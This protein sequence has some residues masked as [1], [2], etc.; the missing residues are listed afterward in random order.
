MGAPFYTGE[1][2][3][4]ARGTVTLYNYTDSINQ[5]WWVYGKYKV[6]DKDKALNGGSTGENLEGYTRVDT[7]D[8]LRLPTDA[9]NNFVPS[10]KLTTLNIREIGQFGSSAIQTDTFRPNRATNYYGSDFISVVDD[11]GAIKV[12]GVGTYIATQDSIP[13]SLLEYKLPNP[14]GFS[15]GLTSSGTYKD[16]NNIT[17][18]VRM[19]GD[20]YSSLVTGNMYWYEPVGKRFLL[21]PK[22]TFSNSVQFAENGWTDGGHSRLNSIIDPTKW[23][24]REGQILYLIAQGKTRKEATAVIDSSKSFKVITQTSGSDTQLGNKAPGTDP[25]LPSGKNAAANN[26]SGT[27]NSNNKSSSNI[28]TTV[29]VRGNF[30]YAGIAAALGS[31]MQMVQMYTLPNESKPASARYYFNPK[32]NQINYQNLGSD[33]T[34]IE[35]VGQVPLV[36]WKNY[37]LMK[38]SFQFIVTPSNAYRP[39]AFG[40]TADDGITLSID[41]TL[42]ELRSMA[43]RPYPVTLFG[44][45]DMLTHQ[46]RFPLTQSR[47]VEFAIA[48]FTIASVHRT[49]TGEINRATCDIT[50]Q[51]LPLEKITLIDMP[52]LLPMKKLP[53][54]KNPEQVQFPDVSLL[55]SDSLANVDG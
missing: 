50:L 30:G 20:E 24:I 36:D 19:G 1:I 51:E 53:L 6:V 48:E 35:R 13:F 27:T 43:T 33:W 37:K 10:T 39:G 28:K 11:I 40:E 2:V 47:G 7:V 42:R 25:K 38:V 9:T 52:K 45:D 4:R 32:P 15:S 49:A 23:S 31:E 12:Y 8:Y 41:D 26:A 18:W 22:I 16:P 14:Y 46:L 21:I 29:K 5:L 17:I 44:F 54:P 3:Y 34:E 55:T